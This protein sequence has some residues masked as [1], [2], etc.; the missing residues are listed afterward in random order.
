VSHDFDWVGRGGGAG[1]EIWR[2]KF[3]RI[4]V[5]EITLIRSSWWR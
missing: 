4:G 1:H 5:W 3:S 2:R